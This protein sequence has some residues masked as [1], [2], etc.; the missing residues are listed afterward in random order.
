MKDDEE[1]TSKSNKIYDLDANVLS[2][3]KEGQLYPSERESLLNPLSAVVEGLEA[4]NEALHTFNTSMK[5]NVTQI[6]NSLS[7][8]FRELHENVR[9]NIVSF[10][11]DLSKIASSATTIAGEL[12]TANSSILKGIN[13]INEANSIGV[14][15]GASLDSWQS[16]IISELQEPFEQNYLTLETVAPSVLKNNRLELPV[17]SLEQEIDENR[18]ATLKLNTFQPTNDEYIIG[19]TISSVATYQPVIYEQLNTIELRVQS[20]DDSQ[21]QTKA[22]I[23]K[24]VET[25]ES[26]G[27]MLDELSKFIRKQGKST[28]DLKDIRYNSQQARL[29]IQDLKTDLSKASKQKK[30]CNA[31]FSDKRK[32]QNG[33]NMDELLEKIAQ[34]DIFSMNRTERTEYKE[35]IRQTAYNLNRNIATQTGTRQFL[36]ISTTRIYINPNLFD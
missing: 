22:T 4:G 12:S 5:A 2:E 13:Q 3:S 31:L 10:S 9:G 20:L 15:I 21:H 14:T 26:Q 7:S 18:S 1:N 8:P 32:V 28:F 36:I 27:E 35:N 33:W 16:N 29:R 19:A 25:V 30:L 24:L 34:R 23:D 6:Q 11:N 17:L